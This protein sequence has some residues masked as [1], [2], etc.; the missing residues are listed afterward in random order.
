VINHCNGFL[1]NFRS[2]FTR[3][4]LAKVRIAPPT[5]EELEETISKSRLVTSSPPQLTLYR[6]T[7]GWCPFCER[8]WLALEIKGISY[9]ES[10]INLQKKPDW[11]LDMVPT[12]LT[13]AVMIYDELLSK[14]DKSDS[15]EEE[16][17]DNTPVPPQRTVI[18]ESGDIL[19][20][21]DDL[22]PDTLPLLFDTPE[23]KA[24]DELIEKLT[25]AGFGYIY[26]GRNQTLSEEE[27]LEKKKTFEKYLNELDAL[28]GSHGE[29]SFILG[30]SISGIDVKI[31]PAMERWRYQMPLTTEMDLFENRPNIQNWFE[32]TLDKFGPYANR[33]VG[34]QYSWTAVSS[35]FL[36]VFGEKD[37]HGN[38]TPEAQAKMKKSDELAESLM[39]DFTSPASHYF[40]SL[41]EEEVKFR[42]VSKIVTNH[43][44]IVTDCTNG[45][46]MTQKDVPR[47]KYIQSADKALRAVVQSLLEKGAKNKD[48]STPSFEDG[49]DAMDASIAMRTIA[50]R[51]CVPRD[52]GA[53]SAAALRNALMRMSQQIDD[54]YNIVKKTEEKV[55]I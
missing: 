42:A 26:A 33:V 9:K 39:K 3:S 53:P 16:K 34:D 44:N 31:I 12:G 11:Y 43:E 21:L 49:A 2:T 22:F 17:V 5:W 50:Q 27:K 38:P 15:E 32:E 29:K 6:D 1:G 25:M 52:M 54:E 51:L 7:N 24:A 4:S 48:A 20:A 37:E 45:D 46:P 18:W 19:Q 55:T 36:T 28:I 10:L 8:V 40:S 30:N 35:Y 23:Y 41:S 47:A 13:P 14:S